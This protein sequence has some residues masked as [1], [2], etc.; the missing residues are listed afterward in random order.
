MSS[1]QTVFLNTFFNFWRYK[2]KKTILAVAVASIATAPAMADV[3]IGGKVEQ[4]FQNTDSTVVATDE[5]TGYTDAI[6]TFSA[7]EDLGNGLS[8]FADIRTDYDGASGALVT[9]DTK[10]GLTGGFGTVV[11]GRMEDFSE[12]KVLGMVD[13]F[14]N[15]GV[16]LGTDNVTRND[17]GIAYV[18]PAYSG[19]T[20][21]VAGYALDSDSTGDVKKGFDA[22]DVALMY[23]NG[24]ITANISRE[25]T[26]TQNTGTDVEDEKI[27]SL[28]L[29]YV[30][31]DLNVRAVWQDLENAA[32][33]AANDHN[34]VMV[35]AV[36]TMGNNSIAVGWNENELTTGATDDNTTALE[37]RH[38]LSSRTRAYIGLTADETATASDDTDT[39]YV[40]MEHSF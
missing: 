25:L 1:F 17:D 26:E 38:K 3:S 2:M 39:Y 32:G 40:G 37:L 13:V 18:S 23:A 4:G 12:A 6:L 19:L 5:W 28:G 14:G 21:G 9:F 11:A 24:P 16:E 15:G 31:G 7:S 34:D 36:Y 33:V 29:G 22:S 8:A 20:I 35:A 27:F 10:V 30:M